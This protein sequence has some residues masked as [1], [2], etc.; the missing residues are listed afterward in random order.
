ATFGPGEAGYVAQLKS[1]DQGFADFFARLANDG[2]NKSNTLF[3]FTADEN[4]HFVPSCTS[5]DTGFAWNHGDV[6]P[7]INTTWLGMVGPGVRHLGVD[8]DVWSDH[9]DTRVTM[10]VLLGPKD[11]YEHEG[12][13]LFEVLE[14]WA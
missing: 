11:D 8:H 12:R 13:A 10:M 14:N 9:T 2:I 7:D 4:D 5:I 6:A 3:V 1:Y